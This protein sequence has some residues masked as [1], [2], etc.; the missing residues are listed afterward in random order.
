MSNSYDS[1][2]S[3]HVNLSIVRIALHTLYTEVRA[4]VR[5]VVDSAPHDVAV[6][7]LMILIVASLH[8]LAHI[9]EVLFCKSRS[10]PV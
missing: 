10:D 1:L 5:R 7:L 3:I 4:A 2:A 9:F 6:S 8:L